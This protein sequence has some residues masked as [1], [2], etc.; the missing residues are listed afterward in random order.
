MPTYGKTLSGIPC[1][2]LRIDSPLSCIQYVISGS[3]IIICDNQSYTVTKG[4]TFL[5]PEGKS[6]IYYSN[7][8]NCFERIWINFKGKLSKSLTDVYELDNSIV[9]HNTD[10]YD[11]L[12]EMHEICRSTS[13]PEEY[14]NKTA[15]VFLKIMQL[16]S[17]N[18]KNNVKRSDKIEQIRLYID[19]H[20]LDEIDLSHIAEHFSF[21]REH[22][23]RIF[24]QTYGITPYQY[25]VQSRIRIAMIMLRTTDNSI[26]KIS[27]RLQFSD[28]HHFSST[29]KSHVG[30]RP[31]EYRKTSRT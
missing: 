4:D 13:D 22:I 8:D 2:Q 15:V 9:F 23:I 29:F 28:A 30:K 31:S 20:I 27:E 5:L 17:Q 12:K 14:K 10:T 1:Y 7:P 19:R 3:G 24:K 21:T 25:I 11:L 18:K 6:Q 26:E 16:L